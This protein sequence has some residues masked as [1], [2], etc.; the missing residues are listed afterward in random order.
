MSLR[1]K[2]DATQWIYD[3]TVGVRSD[4]SCEDDTGGAEHRGCCIRVALCDFQSHRQEMGTGGRTMTSICDKL[5]KFRQWNSCVWHHLQRVT[6]PMSAPN[7]VYPENRI[8]H[9]SS[10]RQSSPK[11]KQHVSPQSSLQP[12]KAITQG[13]TTSTISPR[14]KTADETRRTKTTTST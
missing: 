6:I 5:E 1:R 13:S 3:E 9:N 14:T 8:R 2:S 10:H 7:M 4:S 11:K 12:L